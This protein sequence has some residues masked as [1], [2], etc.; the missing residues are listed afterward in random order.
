MLITF[1][2][3]FVGSVVLNIYILL[4]GKKSIEELRAK[5]SV[6]KFLKEINDTLVHETS[7]HFVFAMKTLG[8]LLLLA[9]AIHNALLLL[10][11]L[12]GI[13]LGVFVAKRCYENPASQNELN[14]LATYINRTMK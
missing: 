1:I 4:W 9:I 14:K 7:E 10:A 11:A 3:T 12:V 2:I 6:G 8:I 5:M 13:A